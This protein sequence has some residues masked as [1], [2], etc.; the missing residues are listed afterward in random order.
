MAKGASRRVGQEDSGRGQNQ[1]QEARGAPQ[2][3]LP[4]SYEETRLWEAVELRRQMCACGC[5]E[6]ADRVTTVEG[7]TVAATWVCFDYVSPARN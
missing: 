3:W 2:P 1:G 4:P 5:G 7:H 6:L